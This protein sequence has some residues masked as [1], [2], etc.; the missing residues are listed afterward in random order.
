MLLD[1]LLPDAGVIAP[2]VFAGRPDPTPI[3][4]SCAG[5]S[6]VPLIRQSE[7]TQ[8]FD[9]VKVGVFPDDVEPSS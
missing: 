2:D 3:D 5:V 6:G 7:V 4:A 9:G 8:R 1:E